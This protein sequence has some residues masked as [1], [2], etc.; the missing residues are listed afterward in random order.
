MKIS[1]SFKETT[2]CLDCK[3]Q[4]TFSLP[5]LCLSDAITAQICA[6]QAAQNQ[7]VLEHLNTYEIARQGY[8][9]QGISHCH[10]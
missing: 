9:A 8:D 4:L 10:S 6:E 2:N 7:A 3:C 1:P 5:F